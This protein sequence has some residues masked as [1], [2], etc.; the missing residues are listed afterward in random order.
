[1]TDDQGAEEVLRSVVWNTQQAWLQ[2]RRDFGLLI[3]RIKMQQKL[4]QGLIDCAQ[5]VRL[6]EQLRA[7][8]A[9]LKHGMA[10]LGEICRAM[11]DAGSVEPARQFL[12]GYLQSEQQARIGPLF[13]RVDCGFHAVPDEELRQLLST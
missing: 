2:D 10:L 8:R 7:K 3:R 1:M 11:E 6:Q 13:R 9:Q 5:T 12:R 4:H